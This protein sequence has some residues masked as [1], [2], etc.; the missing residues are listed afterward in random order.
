MSLVTQRSTLGRY[1]K[2]HDLPQLFN[3]QWTLIGKH[4]TSQ[5]VCNISELI[6]I[7]WA[8]F[9]ANGTKPNGKQSLERMFVNR[10]CPE[11]S[12]DSCLPSPSKC[13][14]TKHKNPGSDIWLSTCMADKSVSFNHS[15]IAIKLE[16][17]NFL[18]LNIPEGYSA[19]MHVAH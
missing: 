9:F 12:W 5:L 2:T 7:T 8:G 16:L 14:L 3:S 15:N 10:R 18:H 17:L 13:L 1:Q 4:I 6:Y 11:W 19:I